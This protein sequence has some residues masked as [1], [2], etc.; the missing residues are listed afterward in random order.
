VEDFL[1]GRVFARRVRCERGRTKKKNNAK[2]RV[3]R[4]SGGAQMLY[5]TVNLRIRDGLGRESGFAGG[6]STKKGKHRGGGEEEEAA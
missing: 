6:E 1:K 2:K 4:G 5:Q 3:L